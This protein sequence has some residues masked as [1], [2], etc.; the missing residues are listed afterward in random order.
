MVGILFVLSLGMRL[1][2]MHN[3]FGF[4]FF[5]LFVVAGSA[6]L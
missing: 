6:K 1:K 5:E 3:N 4:S 2:G